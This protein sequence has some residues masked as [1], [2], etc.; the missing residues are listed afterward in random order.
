MIKNENYISIQGWMV[1]DLKLKG[2]ALIVYSIIYGFSQDGE[3][4]FTGSSKYLAEWCGC[5]RQTIM[6]TLNKLVKDKL[7]IK[8][9][10]FKNKIKF[11]SYSINMTPSQKISQGGVKKF[12]III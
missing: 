3:S 6:T 12:H 11:C 8:H 4:K 2:N 10:D 7:I 9:E 5:S 1:N